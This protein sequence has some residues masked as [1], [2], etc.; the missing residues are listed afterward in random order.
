MPY[1]RTRLLFLCF[2]SIAFF[3]ACRQAGAED[4]AAPPSFAFADVQALAAS[5]A[6]AP[7]AH[8]A[9]QVPEFLRAL[10]Y[11]EWRQ[12]V[13]RHEK[14]I[15]WNG[16]G[17]TGLQP[18]FLLPGFLFNQLAAINVIDENGVCQL[19]F[20]PE[21]IEAPDKNLVAKM[22]QEQLGFAGFRLD[23]TDGKG[24]VEAPGLVGTSHFQFTGRNARF[25]PFARP[26]ALDTALPSGEQFSF[27]RE[28][29]L[30]K[31]IRDD[32]G[33]IVFALM[34]SPGITG[35][36]EF[37]VTPGTSTVLDV[38]ASFH[39][40]KGAAKPAKIGLA[41]MTGMFLFSETGG[42]RPSDY[43]PEVHNTDGL[44]VA[45]DAGWQWTP[46]KNP[47][48]LAVNAFPLVNPRGF[49]LLQRDGNFDHYQDLV[50]RFD[51]SS[52]LWVEPKGDWGAGTVELVEIPGTRDY[53]PNIVAYWVPAPDAP[54]QNGDAAAAGGQNGKNG[55]NGPAF[56]VEYRLYWMPPGSK[57][58]ELG[59]A[60][61]TRMQR[62]AEDNTVTLIIDFEGEALNALPA[63]T[64]LTSVIDL[65]KEVA[66]V[67]K[68]L[69]KNTVTG[70]WRLT[71]TLTPPQGGVL[72]SLLAAR[73]GP[74]LLPIS[75]HLKKGENLAEVLTETWRYNLIP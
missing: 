51:R 60:R 26:L 73:E 21:L 42:A 2:A 19:P 62:T 58:H 57:L 15:L 68:Q 9:K 59:T 44:L 30:R 40:R 6:A 31:P 16:N 37:T 39:A 46:L 24:E 63:D 74:P 64:G 23:A 10:G 18:R 47:Q 34:D 53:H 36:F 48:R 67:D 17:G 11:T 35:A 61:D 33:L 52:S 72:D 38:H 3:T 69:E 65:P 13:Y 50:N 45:D 75:A 49:G 4:E 14:D 28:F 29:W 20:S 66:L 71:L 5:L 8:P 70:G 7:Y 22:Q 55:G 56:S 25:G 1:L 54:P 27:F 12:L 32:A 43:R 41:P